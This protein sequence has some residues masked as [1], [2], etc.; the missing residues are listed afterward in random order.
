MQKGVK[1][2]SDDEHWMLMSIEEFNELVM[3]CAN[4]Q[5]MIARESR[6]QQE[7]DL[8]KFFEVIRSNKTK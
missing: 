4:T 7:E 5:K 3:T 6:K 1:P 2:T 8:S